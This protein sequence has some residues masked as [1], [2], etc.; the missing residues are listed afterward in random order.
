[1]K[2]WEILHYLYALVFAGALT[3]GVWRSLQKLAEQRTRFLPV[4][5]PLWPGYILIAFL[6]WFVIGMSL[7]GPAE[8]GRL[9][10]SFFFTLIFMTS[11]YV[12]VLILFSPL[13][14]RV[15]S[16]VICAVLWLLPEVLVATLYA[17]MLPDE[18]KW[19]IVLPGNVLRILVPVWLA[20]AAVIMG[21][22]LFVH[23]RYHRAVMK[24]SHSADSETYRIWKSEKDRMIRGKRPIKIPETSLAVS[25][26]V[27]APVTIGLFYR[28]MDVVLPERAYTEEELRMILRHELTHMY[29]RDTQ[30]KLFL[31]ICTA[32]LWF[33]PLIWPA[34][35]LCAE[36]L[37]LSCDEQVLLY[38]SQKEK[39]RYADLLL[40]GA[41]GGRGLTTCLSA[42][43][44]GMKYRLERILRSTGGK[45][46][47]RGLLLVGLLSFLLLAFG[48]Q[49][50]LAYG[51]R[52][53]DTV[54]LIAHLGE[55]HREIDAVH[56]QSKGFLQGGEERICTDDRAMRACLSGLTLYRTTGIFTFE[57]TVFPV[58]FRC[59]TPDGWVDLRLTEHFLQIEPWGG[60]LREAYYLR[61]GPDWDV[62]MGLLAQTEK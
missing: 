49:V 42:R 19:V 55:P 16:A 13:I 25:P 2:S 59:N 11:I 8:T 34:M 12:T 31:Q 5:V 52:S 1:M 60:G 40:R 57:E 30:T 58:I 43:A 17:V 37:E 29:R 6:A 38:A 27:K 10:F 24:E 9:L 33:Y 41:E 35:R 45:S 47:V 48:G 61:E 32:L 53:A 7:T 18:P 51:E 4:E 50:S 20:G 44:S 21:R 28:T 23:L 54:D 39:Q 26:A 15:C 3:F 22:S 36:D 56:L 62:L 46:G 14:R